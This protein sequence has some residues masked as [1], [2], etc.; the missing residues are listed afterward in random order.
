MSNKKFRDTRKEITKKLFKDEIKNHSRFRCGEEHCPFVD[1]IDN[2]IEVMAKVTR[3]IYENIQERLLPAE[4]ALP[5]NYEH[6]E[7]VRTIHQQIF[8][9][10]FQSMGVSC[11]IPTSDVLRYY[12]LHITTKP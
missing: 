9:S 12:G 3:G 7:N 5:A 10:R 1:F 4:I 8:Y 11:N 6:E 2:A